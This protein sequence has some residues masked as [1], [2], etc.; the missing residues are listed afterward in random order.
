MSID[1]PEP[2]YFEM[3]LK[4]KKK[5]NSFYPYPNSVEKHGLALC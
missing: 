1:A 3:I 5:K 4:K 2:L